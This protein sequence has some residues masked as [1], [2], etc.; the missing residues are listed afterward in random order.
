[1]DWDEHE[2]VEDLVF[3]H[4][5]RRMH[6][7]RAPMRQLAELLTG[8]FLLF[9]VIGFSTEL[10]DG[11]TLPWS[12]AL[13]YA[14]TSGLNAANWIF[15]LARMQKVGSRAAGDRPICPGKHECRTQ[16]LADRSVASR[17]NGAAC[18]VTFCR[19][20]DSVY[21]CRVEDGPPGRQ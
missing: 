15:V 6:L 2:L 12:L 18:R 17:A 13:L 20:G 7:R 5:H 19:H 11:G 9:W 14:V 1:L 8:V 10:M 21:R 16:A 3:G 4:S